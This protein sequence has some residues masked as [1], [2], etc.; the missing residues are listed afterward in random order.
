[1]SKLLLLIKKDIKLTAQSGSGTFILCGL[2]LLISILS[3]AY[4]QHGMYIYVAAITVVTSLAM[5]QILNRDFLDGSI[6]QIL[7][8][9]VKPE[10]IIYG[11]LISNFTIV[12]GALYIVLGL[13]YLIL[14]PSIS[15]IEILLLAPI[16]FTVCAV[17]IFGSLLIISSSSSNLLNLLVTTPLLTTFLV[18]SANLDVYDNSSALVKD[19][20]S[21]LCISFITCVIVV[22]TCRHLLLNIQS[23]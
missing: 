22:Y 18:Y 5:P 6:T 19:I 10:A 17:T 4:G 16:T 13:D 12:L 14:K 15:M 8:S 2:F 1:M 20:T 23:N 21:L 11:K 7:L 3:I 9:G